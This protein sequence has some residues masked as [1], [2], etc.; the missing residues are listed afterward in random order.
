[1]FPAY[2]NRGRQER[3]RKIE[4][5]GERKMTRE[6]ID[7]YSNRR[8]ERAAGNDSRQEIKRLNTKQ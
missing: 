7:K 5:E 1:M 6:E 3:T 4:K 2:W 8:E